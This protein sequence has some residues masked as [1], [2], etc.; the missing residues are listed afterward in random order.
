MPR[1]NVSLMIDTYALPHD[2]QLD[3]STTIR[4]RHFFSCKDDKKTI[5]PADYL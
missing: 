2:V 4:P 3:S 5:R 1:E